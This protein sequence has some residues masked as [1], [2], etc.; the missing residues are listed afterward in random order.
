MNTPNNYPQ[1]LTDIRAAIL[2][3]RIKAAR[4][5]NK[6]LIQLYWKIGE[7]IVQRQGEEGWGKAVV[8]KLSQDLRSELPDS[9]GFSTRNLWDMRKLYQTYKDYPNLRQAVAE[10][11]WS[12]N[13]LIMSKI[14]D[15]HAQAYYLK[16]A[17][18]NG[19]SRNVLS[20]KIEIDDYA[21]QVLEQSQNNFELA[22]PDYLAEQAN[23]SIKSTYNLEFLGLKAAAK[24][25]EIEEG[26]I[27]KIRDFLIELGYG[28]AF[29]G[30]QYKL[31]IEE[32]EY[33]LDLLFFHRKLNC[34]VVFELKAGEFK[35]EYAGK[36]NFYLEVV[37]DTLKE[38]H[39]NPAIGILLCRGTNDLEVD[40]ALRSVN[41]AIGVSNYQLTK[42]L[43]ENLTKQLPSPDELNRLLDR[44]YKK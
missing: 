23:E 12:H 26:L 32:K 42:A 5:L 25:R 22:L 28:F 16:A 34:L 38:E 27:A 13:L 37:N 44:K 19:W 15:R 31:K 30:S 41:N 36:L 35:P 4:V 6:E 7:M 40:Y 3:A 29:V 1:L 17:A 24:E 39:E 33:F 18:F 8:D 43:P 9:R 10:I 11:P 14:K 21:R 20:I 2:Q